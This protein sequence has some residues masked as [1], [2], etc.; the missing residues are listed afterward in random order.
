MFWYLFK[1]IS[2]LGP[3]RLFKQIIPFDTHRTA[4]LSPLAILKKFK[5]FLENPSI[6]SKNSKFRT[7]WEVMRTISTSFYGNFATIFIQLQYFFSKTMIAML[8]SVATIANR[9]PLK[10]LSPETKFWELKLWI[11]MFRTAL[12]RHVLSPEFPQVI[13]LSRSVS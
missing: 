2:F 8:C 11:M 1:K 7:L 9:I 12:W 13:E 6:W 3:K 4:K 5:F 10:R